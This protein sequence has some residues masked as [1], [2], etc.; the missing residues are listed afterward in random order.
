MMYKETY[1]P[2]LQKY[3]DMMNKYIKTKSDFMIIQEHVE[4]RY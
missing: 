3:R 2:E 4:S 1:K